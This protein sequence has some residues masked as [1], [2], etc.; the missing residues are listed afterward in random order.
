[1]T[2]TETE[3]DHVIVGA[4]AAG[5]VLARRLS[6]DGTQRVLLLEAGDE[7]PPAGQDNPLKDASRLILSG[8]NWDYRANLRSSERRENLL[9]GRPGPEPESGSAAGRRSRALWNRFP[10]QLGKVV[11]GSSAVNGAIAMRG[12]PR[13]FA[14]WVARGNPDWSW[15]QVLPYYRAIENDADF[16]GG[17]HG[18]GGPVPVRRP[19]PEQ[20]HELET[21][22]WQECNKLGVPDLPDL[23]GGVEAGVGPVPANALGGERVDAST[24]YL[25]QARTRPNLEVRTGARATRV[26]FEGTRAVG[27]V[28]VR[29]G[30]LTIARAKNIV[31]SAGAIGTPVIL[32]RSGVGDA[33]LSAVLGLT[34]VVDLPGVGENLAD[35]P[36][37]V[38]WSL[39]KPGVCK[40]GL[41]WRQIAARTR[42]GYDDDV[43]VQLGLLNNVVSTTIPGFVDRLGW[44]MVVGFS[45][46]LMRPKSRGRVFLEDADPRSAPVI[47]LGLGSESEDVDRLMHGVR[48]A[49]RVLRSS[50]IADELEQTQFWTDSM[51]GNDI[52]LRNGVRNIM[53]PGWHAVGS[54]RMG[55]DSDPMAVV[56]QDCRVHGVENLRVV[57]ASVFPSIP[58]VPTNLTTL[59]LAERVASGGKG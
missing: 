19:G 57:D 20:L 48:T 46:M 41:P 38:I 22:F 34:P 40:P 37:V 36:S 43:D 44:P 29:E 11:G 4:G 7:Q 39:P 27:V 3:W 16:P 35:H 30:R 33:R 56:D 2:A 18:S 45:I 5:S 6:E 28:V 10:Y 25:A 9:D 59:M 32:Q 42:S 31:L 53:N 14:D 17:Q 49:W 50:A 24:A 21:A 12:L 8:Y 47:E 55:P 26:L 23:N 58:S 51:I 1:M 52:V 13:D 15:E 54:C